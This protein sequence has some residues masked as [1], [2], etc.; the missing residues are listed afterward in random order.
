MHLSFLKSDLTA[1]GRELHYLLTYS[2]SLL[3]SFFFSSFSSLYSLSLSLLAVA[4]WLARGGPGHAERR[5][6]EQWRCGV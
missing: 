6:D 1:S 4:R 5:R 3:L 2:L